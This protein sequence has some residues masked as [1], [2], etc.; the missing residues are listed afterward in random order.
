MKHARKD[1]N[2]RIQDTA[3]LIPQDEPVFLLRA[4]DPCA[5]YAM[6]EYILQ[7]ENTLVPSMESDELI[8]CV[9]QQTTA[10]ENWPVKKAFPDCPRELLKEFPDVDKESED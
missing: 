1:Y 3:N 9:R 6:Y 5:I 4:Q 10:M 2:E 7:L 8:G